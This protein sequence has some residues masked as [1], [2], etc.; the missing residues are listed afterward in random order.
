MIDA[1]E[2]FAQIS[3]GNGTNLSFIQR[4]R[5]PINGV[6]QSVLSGAKATVC[7]LLVVQNVAKLKIMGKLGLVS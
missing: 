1:I 5:Y 7:V 4:L 2:G 3:D 6:E